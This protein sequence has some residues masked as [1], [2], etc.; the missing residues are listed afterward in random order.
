MNRTT[1]PS[2]P[3]VSIIIPAY[4]SAA[5]VADAITSALAQT[6][7]QREV[8]VIDDGS[9]DDTVGILKSFGDQIRWESMPNGGAPKARNRGLAIS[10]GEVIQF[11]DADDLLSPHKLA[12]QTPALME[13]GA[14][15]VFCEGIEITMGQPDRPALPDKG[16]IDADPVIAALGINPGTAAGLHWKRDLIAI[17]GFREDLP[18]AQDRDLHLRLAV[19]AERWEFM[20][21]VLITSRRREGSISSSTVR[22]YEQYRKILPPLLDELR[23]QG[24]LTPERKKAFARFLANA[25]R[26]CVR[27]GAPQLAQEYFL[28]AQ[29]LCPQAVR[30]SFGPALRGVAALIGPMAACR[31][32]QLARKFS[33]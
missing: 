1:P 11:L 4:N 2:M 32:S 29:Q 12:R 6:Y 30:D 8:I 24:R 10:R 26:N 22:V 7:P 13:S 17:G 25:A 3:L 18:C 33:R 31:L 14:T 28:S 21:E 19:H 27:S 20:P 23:T 9:T 16:T 5:Y 15:A